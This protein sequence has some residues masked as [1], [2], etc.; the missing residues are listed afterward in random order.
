M[1]TRR[2]RRAYEKFG[3]KHVLLRGLEFFL[4]QTRLTATLY[5]S[6]FPKWYQW[7]YSRELRRYDESLRAFDLYYIDP[8]QVRR[9]TPRGRPSDGI[10]N[11]IGSVIG[12]RW[13]QQRCEP[14]EYS[15]FYH[16]RI[17][18]TLLYQA[19]EARYRYGREW[20]GTKFYRTV[21]TIVDEGKS[22]W[23]GCTSIEDINRKC[24]YVDR[25]YESI[26]KEGY[27]TQLELR[28]SRPS[29]DEP[30]GYMNAYLMEV[31]VDITRD[32]EFLLVDGR[33]R[34][35][36]AQMLDLNRIPVTIIVRHKKWM[37]KVSERPEVDEFELLTNN[38]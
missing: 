6:T 13:D 30:F 29:L 12:G 2:V 26:R 31:A 22:E 36:I 37:Q 14:D 8:K 7:R 16:N 34:L 17:C 32:G 18:D 24:T 4:L 33:H 21:A 38:N 1:G 15:L 20:E 9:V 28:D 19:I 11:D 25:L 35:C 23:H 3:L 10:L 5:W 27:K